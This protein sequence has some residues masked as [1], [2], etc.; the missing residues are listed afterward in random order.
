MAP[1]VIPDGRISRVRLAIMTFIGGLPLRRADFRAHSHAPLLRG[2]TTKLDTPPALIPA[3][4]GAV[5]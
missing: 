1:R 3:Y 4:S 2:F 5:S